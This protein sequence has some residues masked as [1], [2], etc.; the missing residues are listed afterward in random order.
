MTDRQ[1]EGKITALYERLSRDDELAGDSN[2]IVNQK[3]YL[4]DYA[5]SHGFTNC[6]DYT[7][8]GFSGGNFDRPAWKQMLADI[9]AGKVGIVLA[10][11]MSRIGREYLQTGYYTEVVFR[12][13]GVRFIAIGNGVD[14][15]DA[16]TGEFVPFLNIMAE[17]YLRDC[18][19]K[20]LAAYQARGK[21][22]KPTS[23]VAIYGYKKDPEDKFHWLIDEEPAA[24]VRRIYQLSING[25]GP[26]VIAN[27]LRDE[28]IE[29]PSVY[30]AKRGLGVHQNTADM[31]R[32][33]DWS[34][35]TV[36][37]ILDRPEYLGH[38]VNF[39]THKESYKSKRIIQ[40]PQEDWQ[41]IENTH[42]PIIDA[43]T[44]ELAQRTRNVT[45]R[46]D[47]V[48]FSNPLTGLVFCADCGK[49]MYNHRSMESAEKVKKGIDPVTGLAPHDHYDCSTYALKR[50]QTG[51]DNCCGHY[52]L[53]SVLRT[54]ILE[55]IRTAS[56]YAI[57]NPEEFARRVREATEVRQVEASKEHK[58]NINKA[59][60]RCNE[61]D[62]LIKKLYESFAKE[63]I[64][65][66]RFEMLITEYE[67][68]Q[69]EL[70]E[71]L[72]SLQS[73]LDAF[74]ADTERVDQFMELAKK[75][76]DF[77]EL[78]T[79]MIYEFVDKILVHKPEKIDGERTQKVE[80][81]LK[82]IGKFQVPMPEPTPEEL[83][84]E[85][86]K[87]KRRRIVRESAAR[88]RAR[89]KAARLAEAQGQ[90]K[91]STKETEEAIAE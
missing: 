78:T 10:K 8:D 29:R 75:Y 74:N 44:W 52:I 84:E 25:N 46:T 64:S 42:E 82:F 22:G 51:A 32:P 23:S 36:S 60:K 65:E 48:G 49:R 26:Q 83:A 91:Q 58:Q 18:S 24:V 63:Q 50:Y 87:K 57:E 73:E 72:T 11:D 76:T 4:L 66:K 80:I 79:P 59:K 17:W 41:I 69:S 21:A 53:T 30:M 27:L 12:Q 71:K 1:T 62:L 45:H 85:A 90:S 5:E 81:Y 3:K 56:T 13:Y 47:T 38:T 54:L 2:S 14:S 43:Q 33:Y 31:S 9:E 86:R 37:I 88:R 19:R 70:M 67:S 6:V 35:R 20:Q 55:T 16:N 28:Q 7:D 39:R 77:S 15:A 89:D 40:L 34:G 68:E 61:L